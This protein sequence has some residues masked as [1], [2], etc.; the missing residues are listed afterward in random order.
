VGSVGRSNT[1]TVIKNNMNKSFFGLILCAP[2]LAGG[3]GSVTAA[4]PTAQSDKGSRQ[5]AILV[6]LTASVETIDYTNREVTL[7]GP[8]GNSVTFV[9]DPAVKR[10]NEVKVG[11]RVQ[12]DYFVS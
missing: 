3:S 4:E 12:A 8:L 7:K 11:D 1:N 10:L 2:L 6:T 9:V 5:E